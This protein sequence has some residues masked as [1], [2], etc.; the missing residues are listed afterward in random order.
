MIKTD[1]VILVTGKPDRLDETLAG[2]SAEAKVGS[3]IV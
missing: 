1:F 2:I 3:G